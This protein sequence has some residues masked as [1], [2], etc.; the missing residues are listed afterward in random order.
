M[1]SL[2]FY[3]WSRTTYGQS[4]FKVRC[5]PGEKKPKRTD[6]KN[7][8]CWSL[9]FNIFWGLYIFSGTWRH[10]KILTLTRNFWNYS[11]LTNKK[12]IKS[13][14]HFCIKT[15]DILNSTNSLASHHWSI[16]Q[17][18]CCLCSTMTSVKNCWQDKLSLLLKVLFGYWRWYFFSCETSWHMLL[19][20][21]AVSFWNLFVLSFVAR[22][23]KKCFHLNCY[24]QTFLSRLTKFN[25]FVRFWS[26]EIY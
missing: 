15:L 20:P 9:C 2:A 13:L 25:V 17:I 21:L 19:I 10:T 1:T 5:S 24:W 23:K 7:S 14:N 4:S 3:S 11:Y 26:W 8:D 12:V 6:F 22:G 16:N 18:C